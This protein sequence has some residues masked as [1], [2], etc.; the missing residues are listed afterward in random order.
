M[1]QVDVSDVSDAHSI[2]DNYRGGKNLR[3]QRKHDSSSQMLNRGNNVSS[4]GNLGTEGKEA[5]TDN[6]VDD[7]KNGQSNIMVALRLRPLWQKEIQNDEF[8]IVKILDQKVV[9]LMD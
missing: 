4:V 6:L 7:M 5:N 3:S 1:K 2:Q 8:S 9:I